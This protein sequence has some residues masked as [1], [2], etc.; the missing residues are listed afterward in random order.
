MVKV[1]AFSSKS[2]WPL[3]DHTFMMSTQKEVVVDGGEICHVSAD[4]L[5]F[6]Q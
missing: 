2:F 6:K 1:L 3:R 5:D 4:S